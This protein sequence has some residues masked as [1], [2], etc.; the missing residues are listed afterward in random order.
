[1]GYVYKK[2]SWVTQKSLITNLIKENTI[3]F[4]KGKLLCLVKLTGKK[5]PTQTPTLIFNNFTQKV[6]S[7]ESSIVKMKVRLFPEQAQTVVKCLNAL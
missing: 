4:K 5:K 1:M 7:F 3:C 2:K 6:K